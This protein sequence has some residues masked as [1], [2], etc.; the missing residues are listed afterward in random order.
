MKFGTNITIQLNKSAIEKHSEETM[1]D[2]IRP[3]HIKHFPPPFSNKI[4]WPWMNECPSMPDMVPNGKP[5]PKISIVTPSYNQGNYLEETIR[6]VILQGYPNLEYI[7]IDGGS[8]D[9]S[10]EIIKKYESWLTYWTSKKDKSQSDA[11]NKGFKRTTGEILAWLNSD[12]YY[13]PHALSCVAIEINASE[14]RHIVMG[15]VRQVDAEGKKV[16]IWKTRTPTFYSFLNQFRL[17]LIRGLVV[18]PSQ[19]SVFWHRKVFENLGLLRTDLKYVMDYEYWLRMLSNGYRFHQISY[20]LSN[21]RFYDL[22]KNPGNWKNS[23]LGWKKIGK[24]YFT[25]LTTTQQLFAEL[26]FWFVV[27]PLSI[28]TLPYRTISY[29]LGIKRG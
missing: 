14:N 15:H 19:P 5:W 26:Y 13:E 1:K 21:Y 2:F 7:I 6:S 11:I 4:G 8:T 9:N 24:E 28:I 22:S 3:S 18:M 29:L 10:I 25:N 12:D 20:I 23:A 16:R 27:F 17:Y